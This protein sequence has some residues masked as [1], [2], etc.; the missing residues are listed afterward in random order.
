MSF[1]KIDNYIIDMFQWVMRQIELFTTLTREDVLNAALSLYKINL[2]IF[3]S[4]SISRFIVTHDIVAPIINTTILIPSIAL[5]FYWL[6]LKENKPKPGTLPKEIV[7]RKT[8]RS[9]DLL[10]F[11]FALIT[12]PTNIIIAFS[13]AVVGLDDLLRAYNI[14]SFYILIILDSII[15]Y[16]FCTTSLPPGEK[17]RRAL[18]KETRNLIPIAAGN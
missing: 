11:I 2:L 6:I 14:T 9:L 8:K 3:A 10:V 7:T 15:E 1:E 18:E 17:E 12:L 4:T 13:L 16:I 5:Y